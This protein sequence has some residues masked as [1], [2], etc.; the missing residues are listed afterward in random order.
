MNTYNLQA[1]R[2]SK[3]IQKFDLGQVS[4]SSNDE[5]FNTDGEGAHES[6]REVKDPM[7]AKIKSK[8]RRFVG[9]IKGF[10]V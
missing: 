8:W 10:K 5:S 9:K 3:T 6:N 4:N 1:D 2:N 7:I